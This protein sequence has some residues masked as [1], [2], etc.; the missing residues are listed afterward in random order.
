MGCVVEVTGQ[1]LKD[2]LEMAARNCPEEN[3]GFLQVSGMTYTIDTSVK[4]GVTLDDKGNFTGVSGAYRVT[5]ITV[6]GEPLD[7]S[8]E[9][10]VSC[11]FADFSGIVYYIKNALQWGERCKKSRRKFLMDYKSMAAEILKNVGGEK[12]VSHFEHCSTRLRFSLADR[13]GRCKIPY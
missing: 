8:E 9:T 5:D 11:V 4:S 1:Q 2:A 6:G 3:G 12:N 10:E 7:R 13:S